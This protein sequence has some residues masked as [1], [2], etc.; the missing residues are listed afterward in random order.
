[1][2]YEN[3]LSI[4]F[5]RRADIFSKSKNH[6]AATHAQ[7]LHRCKKWLLINDF[8]SD[9][10]A[11]EA[12]FQE[13]HS[14]SSLSYCDLRLSTMH[15]RSTEGSPSFQKPFILTCATR[16][17]VTIDWLSWFMSIVFHLP[18][19]QTIGNVLPNEIDSRG[20]HGCFA[21]KSAPRMTILVLRLLWQVKVLSEALCHLDYIE[22]FVQRKEIDRWIHESSFSSAMSSVKLRR[23]DRDDCQWTE[24]SFYHNIVQCDHVSLHSPLISLFFNVCHYVWVE[25]A[26]K[27]VGAFCS[28]LMGSECV[29]YL[30]K[31]HICG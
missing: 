19:S 14:S 9:T 2:M 12:V 4:T 31:R 25:G 11:K 24:R 5:A 13:L 18:P 22:G 27:V 21:A 3:S 28:H 23:L 16:T 8:W 30:T 6:E 17:R 29:I 1:M 26:R 10:Y 20:T 7:C 15:E